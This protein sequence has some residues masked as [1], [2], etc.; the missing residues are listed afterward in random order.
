MRWAGTGTARAYGKQHWA[1]MGLLG[2]LKSQYCFYSTGGKKQWKTK[3]KMSDE[4]T[5]PSNDSHGP[6]W[7]GSGGELHLV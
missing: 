6:L 7:V 2:G 4:Q 3:K 5:L 1:L